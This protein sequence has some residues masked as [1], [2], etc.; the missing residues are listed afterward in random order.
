MDYEEFPLTE[1]LQRLEGSDN[2]QKI[3]KYYQPYDDVSDFGLGVYRV[4][5]DECGQP[6]DMKLVYANEY[7]HRTYVMQKGQTYS[8]F[9][10]KSYMELAEGTSLRWLDI[11]YR[12]AWLGRVI[13]DNIYAAVVNK[14]VKYTA[15]RAFAPGYVLFTLSFI[16]ENPALEENL[17]RTWKTDDAIVNVARILRMPEKMEHNIENALA[18]LARLLHPSNL[19]IVEH[20]EVRSCAYEWAAPGAELVKHTVGSISVPLVHS[21]WTRFTDNGAGAFLKDV[22]VLKGFSEEL[23]YYYADRGVHS[24]IVAPYYY[25]G[26]I[27][28]TLLAENPLPDADLDAV[29]LM[30]TTAF[31]FGEELRAGMLLQQLDYANRHDSLTGIYNRNAMETDLELYSQSDIALG[32]AYIDLNG[33]KQINDQGGHAAGDSA[34]C[35]VAGLLGEVFGKSSV[36]RICGDEFLVLQRGVDRD[37]FVEELAALPAQ[38]ERLQV[39]LAVGGQFVEHSTNLRQE[40]KLADKAMYEDKRCYYKR[41]G[42]ER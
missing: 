31:F 15:K 25:R 23:Y 39:S 26:Q 4:T 35:V 41:L 3:Q 32:V 30:E 8:D 38:A 28:G 42:I 29:R 10:G 17:Q 20:K 13:H 7:L 24:L 33:M 40:M 1:D 19:Y 37:S 21:A 12:A 16:E 18:E 11:A 36:Y 5:L 34:L 6:Q 9:I 14:F 2:L 22:R 27:R